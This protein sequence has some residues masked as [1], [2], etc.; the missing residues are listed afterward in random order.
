MVNIND[1]YYRDT[2]KELLARYT[3]Q[4]YVKK[5]IELQA[6]QLEPG[7]Y[8]FEITHDDW[9]ALLKLEGPCN[10]NP[11]VKMRKHVRTDQ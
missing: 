6:Q 8:H 3:D 5:M 1:D 9:C 11:D 10:C 2:R 4:P 7:L